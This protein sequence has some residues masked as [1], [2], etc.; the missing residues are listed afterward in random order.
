MSEEKIS[1]LVNLPEGF[2]RTRSLRPVL[3]RLGS[4]A[5]V[6]K[7]SH[8][9]PEEIAKDLAWAE[10]VLMWSWPPLLD[11]L[12]DAAPKLRMI[13]QLDTSQGAARVAI[14]RGIPISTG[15]SA[16]SPAVAEMAL[17]LILTVLRKAGDYHAAMRRGDEHWVGSFPDDIDP[18]E[19]QLTGRSVGIVGLGRIGQRL[20]ELLGP[21]RCDLRAYDPYLPAKVAKGVGARLCEL[22]ELLGESEVVVLAAASN[23]GTQHLLGAREIRRL[24]KQALL[25]NV[26][27]AALVDTDA[28]LGR[29]SKGDLFLACDV[30]DAEPLPADHP[31][32]WAPNAYLTPHRAGGVMESVHRIL[33]MLID[34]IE[35]HLAGR[36]LAHPLTERMVDA[37][38][39]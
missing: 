29:V 1:L 18:L 4:F 38:D 22:D 6:R 10:V 35:N 2:Y 26:A 3:A 27:R 8:N 24:R 28:L 33:T 9:T 13:A 14:R 37:L 5:R 30:F 15:R 39:A 17:T 7:R 31:L 23:E 12:L 34:D 25:V 32:R 21:F 16:W 19:R 20:A 11:D 36:K